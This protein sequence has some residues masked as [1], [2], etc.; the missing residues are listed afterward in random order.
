[1]TSKWTSIITISIVLII[2]GLLF[3]AQAIEPKR[4]TVVEVLE[5]EQFA[6]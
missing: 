6:Q 3:F 1:M 2:G 4:E 5:N